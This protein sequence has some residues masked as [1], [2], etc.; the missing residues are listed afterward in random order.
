MRSRE[1]NSNVRRGPITTPTS[2]GSNRNHSSP[3]QKDRMPGQNQKGKAENR[4]KN[5]RRETTETGI[6]H[7][8]ISLPMAAAH[9]RAAEKIIMLRSF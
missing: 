8:G 7:P 5:G 1:K 9:N 6:A 4:A 2:K 3:K